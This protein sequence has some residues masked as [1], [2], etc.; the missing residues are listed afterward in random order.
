MSYTHLMFLLGVFD[1]VI[2]GVCGYREYLR[3]QDR[4]EWRRLTKSR[5]TLE[6]R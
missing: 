2:Y 4:R 1:G 6:G 5:Q 3:W